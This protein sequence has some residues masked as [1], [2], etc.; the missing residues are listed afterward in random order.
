MTVLDERIIGNNGRTVV[1]HRKGR[2]T[3]HATPEPEPPPPVPPLVRAAR[4]TAVVVTI[5]IAVASFIL[6]FTGLDSLAARSGISPLLAWLWPVV[7]DGTIVQATGALVA[8][9]EYPGQK[10]NRRFFWAVLVAAVTVSVGGNILNALIAGPIPS[11]LAAAVA[12]VAPL[13]LLA[14]THG[15]AILSRFNPDEEDQ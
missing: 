9:S 10:R 8:L 12:A 1:T 2:P 6:S 14:T 4:R 11:P 15:L 7:V 13:S 3:I 5:T